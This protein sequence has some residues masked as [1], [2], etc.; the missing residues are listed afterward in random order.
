MLDAKTFFDEN[1][2]DKEKLR[3]LENN[4]ISAFTF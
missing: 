4:V 2:P 3:K 1:I